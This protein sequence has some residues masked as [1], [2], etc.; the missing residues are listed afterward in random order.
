MA[1]HRRSRGL[2]LSRARHRAPGPVQRVLE[3]G[4]SSAIVSAAAALLVMTM[5]VSDPSFNS[6]N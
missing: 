4:I 1:K 6:R 2:T 5:L 3:R